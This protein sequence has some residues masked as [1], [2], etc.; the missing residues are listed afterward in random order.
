M[1]CFRD[2][3]GIIQV[4]QF[5]LRLPFAILVQGQ[6][7]LRIKGKENDKDRSRSEVRAS[8]DRR[9]I[10]RFAFAT[11]VFPGASRSP[12]KWSPE[13]AAAGR[14]RPTASEPEFNQSPLL[15][16][17]RG[18]TARLSVVKDSH[19]GARGAEYLVMLVGGTG[20]R[21]R[22]E[23]Y[24][25]SRW[26]AAATDASRVQCRGG[27]SV[28]GWLSAAA[29]PVPPARDATAVVNENCPVSTDRARPVGFS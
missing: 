22:T 26:P 23:R 9:Y 3:G 10:R 4:Q 14:G 15:T 6:A 20:E 24:G 17:G 11:G 19:G 18:P 16:T 1:V 28:G 12:R 13:M 2:A 5:L 29:A 21:Y 27:G 8:S 7:L 25:A